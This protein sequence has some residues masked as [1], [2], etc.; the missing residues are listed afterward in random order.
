[1]LPL[2]S[3]LLAAA[4][5]LPLGGQQRV[6]HCGSD[7]SAVMYHKD[8][9]WSLYC[10]RC[11]EPAFTPRPRESLSER[12]ARIERQR[13][14]EAQAA[15]SIVP[16][17]PPVTDPKE[18]PLGAKVWL[19][20][21]G[22]SNEDI[23]NL[24]IYYH[25]DT[26][27]VVIP[28]VDEHGV[29]IYWQARAYDWTRRSTRPKYL[30]P[31]QVSAHMGVWFEGEGPRVLT[32]DYLSAYRVSKAGF[33]TATLMGTK[34]SDKV[35]AR[36]L[37][38]GRQVLVWL[39]NDQGRYMSNPGQEAAATIVAKLRSVGLSVGNV[40]G[41]KDPKKYSR[42]EIVDLLKGVICR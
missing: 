27:R 33:A 2:S 42:R 40:V 17:M 30:N 35:L 16:P 9:G 37:T 41:D 8:E 34:L 15:S 26:D 12:L 18:W 25:A 22:F 4:Q 19:Y 13:S 14:T 28:V 3:E 38:E 11:G 31:K 23:S 21:A 1:M 5:A 29:L 6:S 32:E 39:D 24:G 20:A 36:L 7:K 10:H